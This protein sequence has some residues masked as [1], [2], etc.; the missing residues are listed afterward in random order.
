[1]KKNRLLIFSIPLAIFM[2]LVGMFLYTILSGKDPNHMPSQLIDRPFPQFEL[3]NLITEQQISRQQW[4]GKK[5][6]V[7][8]WA[9][10]CTTCIAE[11]GYLTELAASGILIYGVNYNDDWDEA[12][13]FL[14][15]RGNPYQSVVF[16][17]RGRLAIN[18]GVYGAPETFIVDSTG[19]I[20]YRHVGDVNQRVWNGKLKAIWEQAK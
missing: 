8:V 5:A 2:I 15:D 18:L 10:W 7:N 13:Q 1:M 4:V 16:D 14:I 6:L 11:H 17:P 19:T 3:Q 9:T 20:L 12:R